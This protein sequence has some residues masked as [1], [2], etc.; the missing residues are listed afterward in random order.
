MLTAIYAVLVLSTTCLADW[1]GLPTVP[2]TASGGGTFDLAQ[3]N[4]IVVDTEYADAKDTDGWTLIPPSLLAFAETFAAD[5]AAISPSVP[6]I[7]V[8]CEKQAAAGQVFLTVANNSDFR[9]AAD[10]WTS[11]AYAINVTSTGVII[12]GASPLGVWWGTRSLLQQAALHD[13]RIE[14]GYGVDSPGWG[15]RGIFVSSLLLFEWVK[16]MQMHPTKKKKG[17]T[18]TDDQVFFSLISSMLADITIPRNS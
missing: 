15:T 4:K 8:E 9:D 11:E 10:R 6:A 16:K 17:R 12:T 13:G 14:T 2:F 5:M 18:Y 7:S 1:T 3:L